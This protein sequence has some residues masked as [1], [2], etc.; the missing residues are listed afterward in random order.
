MLFSTMK[1]K[2]CLGDIDTFVRTIY[3]YLR[4]NDECVGDTSTLMIWI[5][6]SVKD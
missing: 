6:V 3:V 2:C 1:L 5:V 4:T